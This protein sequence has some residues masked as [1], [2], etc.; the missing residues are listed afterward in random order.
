M[1]N[2]ILLFP[3]ISSFFV[4]LFML[5]YW[6]RKA[7]QINLEWPDM[8]KSSKTKVAGSGGMIA[9]LGFIIG[10][11]IYVAYVVFILQSYNSQIIEIL[12]LLTVIVLLSS[13]GFVDDILG[14]QHGGLRRRHRIVIIALSA[15][16]LM[17][18]NA[19]K[20]LISIPFL[21]VADIGILY[22]LIVIPIGIVGATA[23]FNFLAGFNGLEA[24]QGIIIL[25]ALS[26][27]SYLTGNSWLALIL[28]C[29]VS[30]LIAF[31]FYNFYPAKVFPGDSLTY[32]VGA[33]IAI[34]AILGDFERIAVFFFIPYILEFLLKSRGGLIK[35]SFGKPDKN[36]TL[37]LQYE[38]IYGLTHLSIFL[39]KKFNIRPT[40]KSVVLSIWLFQIIIVI[41]GF[42]FFKNGIFK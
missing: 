27:V 10:V 4:T 40:E 17:A 30:S 28:L 32:A 41:L 8:N 2:Y 21:G 7:R 23:T 15:I 38:K 11:L 42:I 3:L 34:A 12:A 36:N 25:S 26:I 37:N 5:P 16:P 14:W 22:P 6:L 1:A 35:Q 33:L 13:L 29:M 39:M 19:G 31:L 20:S 24:G 18:I 9:V